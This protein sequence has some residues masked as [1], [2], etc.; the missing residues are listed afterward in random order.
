LAKDVNAKTKKKASRKEIVGVRRNY[1]FVQ[2]LVD[3]FGLFLLYLVVMAIIDDTF[4]LLRFNNL[5][6]ATCG[7]ERIG[8][9][10]VTTGVCEL[11]EAAKANPYPLIVWGVLALLIFVAGIVL[12]LV[13]KKRTKLNQKQYDMWVYAVLLI[14]ILLLITVFE[15]MTIHLK[16]ITRQPDGIFS[17]NI[18]MNAVLIAILVRFTQFRIRKAE[19]KKKDGNIKITFKES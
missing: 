4:K 2:F 7:G 6:R 12:P 3:L 13:Y 10:C 19:T 11:T 18:L 1:Q 17:L 14:R 16:F 9:E 8:C 5:I 15:F